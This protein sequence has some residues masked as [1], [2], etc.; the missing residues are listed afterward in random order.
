MARDNPKS[1]ILVE[2][3]FVQEDVAWLDVT[4]QYSSAVKVPQPIANVL[5]DDSHL[6]LRQRH[7]FLA[8]PP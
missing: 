1:H 5:E 4:V 8:H 3:V 2:A 7:L 6:D